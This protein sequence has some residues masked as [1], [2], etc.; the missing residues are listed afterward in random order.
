MGIEPLTILWICSIRVE[1][2]EENPA[3]K[4]TYIFISSVKSGVTKARIGH[5]RF[6]LEMDSPDDQIGLPDSP[7]ANDYRSEYVI[8]RTR[9]IPVDFCLWGLLSAY[10]QYS[11]LK[12][13]PFPCIGWNHHRML[14]LIEFDRLAFIS[15]LSYPSIHS[16]PRESGVTSEKHVV[17]SRLRATNQLWRSIG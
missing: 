1:G 11:Q 7:L 16:T 14:H 12:C 9:S 4:S 6:I 8:Y 17:A 3:S 2:R 10:W 5:Y 13:L 15:S